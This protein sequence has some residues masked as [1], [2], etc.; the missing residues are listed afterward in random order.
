[1]SKLPKNVFKNYYFFPKEQTHPYTFLIP[2]Y[3]YYSTNL[4]PHK[5]KNEYWL[6]RLSHML[7]I[8]NLEGKR[9]VGS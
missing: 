4:R 3:F 7:P 5:E 6:F 1:M 8:Y 2:I 9:V